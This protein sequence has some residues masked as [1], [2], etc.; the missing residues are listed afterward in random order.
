MVVVV[1]VRER[2][3]NQV[4]LGKKRGFRDFALDGGGLFQPTLLVVTTIKRM[5]G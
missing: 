5:V 3:R 2:E 1:V 4:S